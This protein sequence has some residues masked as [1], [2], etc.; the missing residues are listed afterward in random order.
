[1][2]KILWAIPEDIFFDISVDETAAFLNLFRRRGYS[3][4]SL[5]PGTN[6]SKAYFSAKAGDG[7][8]AR[9]FITLIDEASF[10]RV[11]ITPA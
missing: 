7:K 9:A 8:G 1:M 2:S 3:Q 4:S 10:K 5:E 6:E 11:T